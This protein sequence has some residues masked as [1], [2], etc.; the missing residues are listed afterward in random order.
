VHGHGNVGFDV[1]RGPGGLPGIHGVGSPNREE[2]N[3]RPQAAH[4]GDM[5]SVPGV[6]KGPVGQVNDKP[7]PPVGFWVEMFRQVIGRNGSDLQAGG[8]YFLSRFDLHQVEPVVAEL[9]NNVGRTDHGGGGPGQPLNVGD[10][11]VVVVGVGNQDEVGRGKIRRRLPRVD[12]ND[13]VALNE[14]ACV[15]QPTDPLEKHRFPPVAGTLSNCNL[16][17][18]ILRTADLAGPGRS[19]YTRG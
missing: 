3:R 4:L 16:L 12:V 9:P 8:S 15:A 7:H 18:R 6:V 11:K 10:R 13:W 2:G 14:K 5:V 1:G 17:F 19:G